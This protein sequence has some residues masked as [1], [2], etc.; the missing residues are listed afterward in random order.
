MPEEIVFRGSRAQLRR[1]LERLPQVLA[2]E[3]PDAHGIARGL[4][5]RLGVALLSQVQQAFIVKSRGGRGSDGVKWAPLSPRTLTARRTGPGGSADILRDTGRLLRSL[6]PGVEDRP[7]NAPEQVFELGKG[8][9]TIG[10]NCPYAKFHQEGTERI[11]ARPIVPVDG[12]LPERWERAIEA[13]A[14]R[15]LIAAVE[16]LGRRG[17]A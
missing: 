16:E 9:L 14:V 13:A 17:G 7:S 10:T 12:T 11:P 3:A 8:E 15:G 4:Q 5:L 6:T 2:G 1:A